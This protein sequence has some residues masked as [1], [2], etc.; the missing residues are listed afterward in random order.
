MI[1]SQKYVLWEAAMK[2]LEI[3]L[4]Q[5][6]IK[7]IIADKHLVVGCSATDSDDLFE[8]V[9]CEVPDI[10]AVD[11]DVHP[12]VLAEIES[13]RRR[14]VSVPVVGLVSTNCLA[15]GVRRAEFL[16]RGGNDLLEK[17]VHPRE[18]LAS[19][20]ALYRLYS[21]SVLGRSIT[22]QS[23]SAVIS[24][25]LAKH[26]ITVDDVRLTLTPMEYKLIELLL[27]HK[28]QIVSRKTI[29]DSLYGFLNVPEHNC[30]EVLITRLRKKFGEINID[31]KTAIETVRRVGY[32]LNETKA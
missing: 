26:I 18:F 23:N 29:Q 2:I 4:A 22:A 9:D 6:A 14:E 11:V 17:P 21:R 30:I 24:A 19:M 5:N 20:D 7:A 31:A 32:F 3:G 15:R 27:L 12:W 8:Y 28:G 1:K 25:D 16:E 13:I 10:I